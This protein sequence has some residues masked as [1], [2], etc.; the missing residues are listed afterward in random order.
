MLLLYTEESAAVAQLLFNCACFRNLQEVP[1]LGISLFN[2]LLLIWALLQLHH[3]AA[4]HLEQ[5][6]LQMLQSYPIRV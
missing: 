4:R 3:L 6:H 5:M 1:C 2:S